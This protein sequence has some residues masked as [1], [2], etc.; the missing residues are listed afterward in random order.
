[1]AQKATP[2]NVA[3]DMSPPNYRAAVQRIRTIKAKKD[4]VS[5]INGEI[6]D[7]W[8][9]VESHKVHK[10][11]GKDFLRLDGMEPE[12]RVRYMRD[13]NGLIDAAGWDAT[14]QDMVDIAEDKVVH[15][16]FGQGGQ[17][18]PADDEDDDE[19]TDPNKGAF[20]RA[21]E[22]LNAGGGD[23]EMLGVGDSTDLA[24]HPEAAE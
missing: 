19:T 1:M 11:A 22:H 4:R 10:G 8:T 2:E 12:E 3:A 16:R 17:A 7:V 18:A 9:K 5:G 21:R 6:A 15:M 20:A 13:L 14:Q 24:D 23:D